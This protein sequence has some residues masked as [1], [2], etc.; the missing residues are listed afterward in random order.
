MVLRQRMSCLPA[1]VK[2]PNPT[3]SQFRGEHRTRICD[4]H[5][6]AQPPRP[7]FTPSSGFARSTPD[8]HL[9]R[10][11]RFLPG[12]SPG[13]RR[14]LIRWRNYSGLTLPP[15]SDLTCDNISP[16]DISQSAMIEIRYAGDRP[17]QTRR[18]ILVREQML[19]PRIVQI[20]K[21]PS[22][23]F[24]PKDVAEA[25]SVENSNSGN[26][27]IQTDRRDFII[28]KTLEPFIYQMRT[29]P[30]CVF[31]QRISCLPSALKSPKEL[32]KFVMTGPVEAGVAGDAIKADQRSDAGHTAPVHKS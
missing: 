28:G 13:S 16:Q 29:S 14:R 27:P 10:D 19:S 17:L 4:N 20:A 6:T 7:N 31:R 1:P 11:Q 5:I 18:W 15:N 25:S 30:V 3:I 22:F 23:P 32:R 8:V 26:P 9:Q 2:S 24:F 21:L 12:S